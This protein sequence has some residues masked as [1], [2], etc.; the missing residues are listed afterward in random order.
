MV[1]SILWFPIY[2][3]LFGHLVYIYSV[4]QFLSNGPVSTN[5]VIIGIQWVHNFENN[6]LVQFTC[7]DILGR[8]YT[9]K[10][11]GLVVKNLLFISAVWSKIRP[12]S[13]LLIRPSGFGLMYQFAHDL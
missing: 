1:F 4:V 13:F 6:T 8:Y 12:S 11:F 5:L 9:S 3:Y 10:L 2:F 7:C